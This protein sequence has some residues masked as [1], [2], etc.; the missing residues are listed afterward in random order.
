[1]TARPESGS[2]GALLNGPRLLRYAVAG[3]LSA[4]THLGTMTVLVETGTASPV[5]ASTIGFVLSIA[6]SY[7]LQKRWVFASAARHLPTMLKFLVATVV[8]LVLNAVVLALGT[9][10][11]SLNYLL[12]QLVALVLIPVSNYLINSFWTFR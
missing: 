10:V 4:L 8:A 6:V 9:E 2:T 7:T 11:W 12:V 1:M 3:G 5:I